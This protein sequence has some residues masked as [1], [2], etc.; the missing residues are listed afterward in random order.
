M[1]NFQGLDLNLLMTLDVLLKERNVTRAAQR[2]HLSQPSVS[3]QLKKLREMFGDPLLLPG[4]RGMTPTALAESLQAPLADA[5]TALEQAVQ[6]AREFDPTT[7]KGTWR[8]AAADYGEATILRHALPS[9]LRQAPQCRIAVSQV[10][11]STLTASMESGELE[12][13]FHTADAAP[14]GLKSSALFTEHYVLAG[15]KDHPQ[16]QQPLDMDRFCHLEHVMVSPNGGGFSGGT[17][18]VLAMLGHKRKVVLSVPHF[19]FMCQL[20]ESSDLVAM[21]PSRL[22]PGTGLKT[23]PVPFQ[24][25]SFQMVMLWHEKYHNDTA[26]RWLRQSIRDSVKAQVAPNS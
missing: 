10:K 3:V 2:L 14:P 23:H 9:I 22:I 20:L 25:P 15:R 24:A 13:A 5:L 16:L 8:L 7:A 18:Q 26:H 1:I 6:P 12:L 17:D 11:P 21:V 4:P 19:N